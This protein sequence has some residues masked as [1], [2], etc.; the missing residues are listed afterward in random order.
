M[1]RMYLVYPKEFISATSNPPMMRLAGRRA[2]GN[3]FPAIFNIGADPREEENI[4][5]TS[6]W[7][8]GP[9]LKAIC[10]YKKTLENHPNPRAISLTDFSE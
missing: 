9:Y 7:V 2:E 10:E 3:G 1:R 8:I 4:F 6:A 5:G